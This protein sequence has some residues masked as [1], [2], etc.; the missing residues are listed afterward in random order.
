MLL[1]TGSYSMSV[2]YDVSYPNDN[3]FHRRAQESGHYAADLYWDGQ[4]V[5]IGSFE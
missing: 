4:K 2:D 3:P 1:V 5:V